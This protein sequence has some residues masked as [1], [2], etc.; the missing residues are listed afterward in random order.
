MNRW[1][2]GGIVAAVGL[3]AAAPAIQNAVEGAPG[4]APIAA[5]NLSVAAPVVP[6]VAP[7]PSAAEIST[8]TPMAD[9]VAILGILNKRNGLSRDLRMRP[10]DAVH[11]G[12]VVVRLK[13]CDQTEPWEKDQLTG[14]F[15]QL[16]VHGA[17]DKWRKVFSGW[18][19]KE[20][21]SL[22]VVPHP[23]YDVWV[24]AC[25]MRHPDVGPNTV[26]LSGEASGGAKSKARKSAPAEDAEDAPDEPP[27]ATPSNAI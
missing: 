26:V 13:A 5:D 27:V 19:F 6:Q 2:I 23:I 3:A 1:L 14:A 18:L 25:T 11:I 15:V 8:A 4:E 22:N 16:I 20:S 24:K 7:K 21:P 9:R 17:D 12:D 10:G